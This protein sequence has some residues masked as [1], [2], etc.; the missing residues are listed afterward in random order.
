MVSVF[1][2][3]PARD[4]VE[5]TMVSDLDALIETPITFRLHGKVH[6]IK[7]ISTLMF[8]EVCNKL[9]A[10]QNVAKAQGST[11]DNVIGG[12]FELFRSVCDSVS[13]KDV[14]DMTYAQATALLSIVVQHIQ[15]KTQL[16][17]KKIVE[18]Q[19]PLPQ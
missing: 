11:K 9:D 6:T 7:P 13:R 12:Y 5:G 15:G 17:K 4:Q 19:A 18:P 3:K 8:F 10:V 16:E 2:F 1:K 14:E